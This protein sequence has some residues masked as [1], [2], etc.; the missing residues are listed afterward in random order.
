MFV[1]LPFVQSAA[2]NCPPKDFPVYPN[3]RKTGLT[4]VVSAGTSATSACTVTLESDAAP[5]DVT[6]FYD[7]SLGSGPWQ[8]V[9]KNGPSGE[10]S[11]QRRGDTS[12][13]G[14]IRF[15]G[16]A[17]QTRIEMEVLT[18]QSTRP[19]LSSPSPTSGI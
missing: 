13:V 2:G 10:W 14:R 12:T 8:L 9:N 6:A 3:A 7:T 4:Y 18:G 17:T 5:S 11:F 1:F 19:S 16:H 15:L